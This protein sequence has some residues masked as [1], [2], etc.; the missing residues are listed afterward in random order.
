MMS[1]PVCF[2]FCTDTM[3]QL[4]FS[5]MCY[6][7]V[8]AREFAQDRHLLNSCCTGHSTFLEVLLCMKNKTKS[9]GVVILQ[10]SE[11]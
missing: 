1:L 2:D 7:S 3:V 5:L 10:C 6:I 9:S 4:G 8:G 11:R